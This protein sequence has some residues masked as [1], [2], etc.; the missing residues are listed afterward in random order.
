M[1]TN[2]RDSSTEFQ[3]IVEETEPKTCKRKREKDPKL[4]VF[5][6]SKKNYLSALYHARRTVK[7]EEAY[8]TANDEQKKAMIL[9]AEEDVEKRRYVPFSEV[10]WAE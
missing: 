8:E 1:D 3:K 9:E 10:S 2:G 6:K 4:A 5:D 7:S